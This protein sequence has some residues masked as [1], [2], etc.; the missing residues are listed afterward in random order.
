M[1]KVDVV[2]AGAGIAGCL[3]ARDLASRGH[4]V[5]VV[6][7]KKK[8]E[9]LGHDWWDAITEV[10][11]DDVGMPRPE[12]PEIMQHVDKTKM[13]P[14]LETMSVETSDPPGKIH[15]DRR[16]LAARQLKYA[17]DAGARFEFD[18]AVTGPVLD[19]ETVEGIRVRDSDGKGDEIRAR[20]TI[21][22][23]GMTGAIRK[24]L[25][26][27]PF[28]PRY[29][30]RGD[31]FVTYREIRNI[32]GNSRENIVVFGKD[33]GVR[34]INRSQDGLIDFFAGCLNYPGRRSPRSI[35][36]EMIGNTP[37]A[38][39]EVMRG[40]YGAPI[41]VRHCFDSFVGPGVLLCGDSACQCNPLDGSGMASSLR[42]AHYAALTA[43]AAL[44]NGRVDV[45]SLWEYAVNYKRT[46][47]ALFVPFDA[48]QKFMISIPKTSLE[49][50]FRR[51]VVSAKDFWGTGKP[52][53]ESIIERLSKLF[54]LIDK[55][56][57]LAALVRSVGTAKELSAHYEEFPEN[58]DEQEFN[59]WRDKKEI[60]FS[61]IPGKFEE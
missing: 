34:W 4:K 17:L 3:A 59:R 54:R 44:E 8:P 26:E 53:K 45:E 9:D 27:S 22:A 55:P 41:P 51:G 19:G 20:L 58:Y 24:G 42:A 23:S 11:F 6:D 30:N 2:I 60:L 14:P 40:G 35:V 57:F 38:G 25:P 29:V 43:H 48:V 46:Q 47:G 21:D 28:F 37:D 39:E 15:V 36:Q 10:V 31:T 32:K 18:T 12:P 5:V 49:M 33:N 52:K 56:G 16:H 7:R 50:L 13:F 1:E 61:R